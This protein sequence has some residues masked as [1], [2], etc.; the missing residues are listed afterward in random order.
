MAKIKGNKKNNTLK[1]TK[2][3]DQIYGLDGDDT[4]LGKAG[5]DKLFGGDGKDV[6]DGGLGDDILKG[7]AGDDLMIAGEGKQTYVGGSGIDTVSYVNSKLAVDVELLLGTGAGG[8]QFDKFKSIENVDGSAFNDR[9]EGDGGANR[10]RGLGGNDNLKGGAGNDI[11]DGGDGNDVLEGGAGADAFI[12]GAGFDTVTYVREKS[13]VNVYLFG[14]ANSG[15]AAGDTFSGIEQVTG[16]L[17]NDVIQGDEAANRLYGLNGADTINGRG[18][19]DIIDGGDGADLLDGGAGNDLIYS[20]DETS[21]SNDII[22]GGAGKDTVSYFGA[23]SGVIVDLTANTSGGAAL[24]DSYASVENV[25]GTYHDDVLRPAAGGTAFGDRGNDTIYDV[26][27]SSEVLRGGRGNDTLS[28]SDSVRDHFVLEN[29][30]DGT[31]DT[32]SGFNSGGAANN[33]QFW[34][35]KNMFAGLNADA[36]GVLATGY[37]INANN[38]HNATAAHA[39][40]IYQGDTK[41]IWYDADGTGSGAAVKIATLTGGPV[42]LVNADF[43]LVDI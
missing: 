28:D 18:G 34:L 37:F 35:V 21:L 27:G 29:Y 30:G 7:G 3:S 31:F 16:T 38:N 17:Y 20:A 14:A 6:L 15:A 10:L 24:G 32:V 11:L 9:I 13:A 19:N 1:G 39:Q 12:G 5:N 33:D 22:V 8:A 4:L 2:K 42:T 36:Q 40:L 25:I 43:R 41:S 26:S 23:D